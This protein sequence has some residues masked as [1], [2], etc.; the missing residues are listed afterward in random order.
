VAQ[1][2]PLF[3][4]SKLDI[5]D[6]TP[7]GRSSSSPKPPSR[8]SRSGYSSKLTRSA[9]HCASRILLLARCENRPPRPLMQASVCPL[10]IKPNKRRASLEPAQL[11]RKD[12]ACFSVTQFDRTTTARA[13]FSRLARL[14][15]SAALATLG[16]RRHHSAVLRWGICLLFDLLRLCGH[17][18][19]SPA[20]R[21]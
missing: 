19:S 11:V 13:G 10:H 20:G 3:C 18:A 12:Q 16:P 7:A 15:C 2:G 6:H 1:I 4:H 17:C 21:C 14:S 9:C 5:N 8:R